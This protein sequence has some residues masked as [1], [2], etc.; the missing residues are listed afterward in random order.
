M[1]KLS[2]N[3]L[4]PFLSPLLHTLDKNL[5]NTLPLDLRN[6]ISTLTP[7]QEERFHN[8]YDNHGSKTHLPFTILAQRCRG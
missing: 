1:D 5:Q 7:P 8:T 3:Q 6:T 4:H 2:E